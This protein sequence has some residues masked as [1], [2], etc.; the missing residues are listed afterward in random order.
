MV[1]K[2]WST[3]SGVNKRLLTVISFVKCQESSNWKVLNNISLTGFFYSVLEDL[4]A[5][6][7]RRMS[8]FI[9]NG[10]ADKK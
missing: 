7:D 10:T 2:L 1:F 6:I 8:G 9:F 5:G 4:N 3:G